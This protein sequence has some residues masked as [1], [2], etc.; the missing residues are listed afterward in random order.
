VDGTVIRTPDQR[1][2]VFVSS[3]LAELAEE[4]AAVRE[5]IDRLHLAPVMFELGARP[6]P[7]RDLYR[8]YLEQSQVFIGIYWERYGWVAPGETASGLEDEYLLSQG[9]PRLLYVKTPAP[10]REPRLDQLL[11]RVQEDDTASYKR[12]RTPEE[13]ARLVGNDLALLLSERF[14]SPGRPT[15]VVTFLA[16]DMDTGSARALSRQHDIVRQA[17][18]ARGGHIFDSLD[19]GIRAAFAQPV[20]AVSAA[21]D[22][23][24]TVHATHWDEREPP[25]VRVALHSGVA[26]VREDGYLGPPLQRVARLLDAAHG[27]QVLL[28]AAVVDVLGDALPPGLTLR[29][30]GVHRLTDLARTEEIQQLVI[31]GIRLDFPPLRTLDR[32][33][34]NLPVQLSS[35]VGRERELTDVKRALGDSRLVTLTGVGGAG[36]SRLALQAAADLVDD[37]PD[38]V[39]LIEL[40][41]LADPDRAPSAVAAALAIAED[42]QRPLVET[43]A[44]ELRS[45]RLLIV[46]DNCEH[47]LA[48]CAELAATLLQAA[49]GLRILATSREGLA[50][51]GEVIIPVPSLAVPPEGT[52]EVAALA[53]YPAVRLFSERAKAVRPD[54]AVTPANA[55]AVVQI[56]TRL[57]GIPLALELAAARRA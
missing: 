43:L 7:P 12:F 5:M 21:A 16:A 6:H 32:R 38:G 25:A 30:L 18:T 55:A 26:E 33:R 56:V 19:R 54:F 34:H 17:I 3:T 42:P 47:M 44:A 57:D 1:L 28:S 49:P 35:F 23:Q 50:V 9:M 40:A 22:L 29:S 11:A 4:R 24:R 27:G 37:F 48:T 52:D 2:R 36:K 31:P 39:W 45:K 53:G 46:V 41:P 20:D 13:L 51:P 8:A 10:G 15:G 14:A